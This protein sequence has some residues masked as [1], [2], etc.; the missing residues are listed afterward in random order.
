MKTLLVA[1]ALC[2][3]PFTVSAEDWWDAPEYQIEP[4]PG[5]PPPAFIQPFDNSGD[6]F[7][8]PIRQ[9]SGPDGTRASSQRLGNFDY[10]RDSN[11]VTGTTQR[12]GNF[13]YSNYSDGTNCVTQH[14]QG[15]SITNCR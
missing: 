15:Q 14:L 3:I 13:D 7:T 10:Y 8:G 12:L 4:L 5:S 2:C 9:Y 11:G 6:G 1:L